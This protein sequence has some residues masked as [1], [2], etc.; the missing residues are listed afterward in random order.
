MKELH[1]VPQLVTKGSVT[2]HSIERK[3]NISSLPRHNGQS[4]AKGISAMLVNHFQGIDDIPLGFG[5]FLT[6]FISD[7]CVQIDFMEGHFSHKMNSHHD[8][9]SYPEKQDVK[10]R[11]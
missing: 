9:S 7:H 8:H 4:K 1:C 6:L 11:L 5:H 10:S 2:F 3:L